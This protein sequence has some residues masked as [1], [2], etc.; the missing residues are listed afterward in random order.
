MMADL[1]IAFEGQETTG[2][3]V[4]ERIAKV[5]ER[6][7]RREITK[8]EEEKMPTLKEKH[9][10]PT[11]I[12]NTQ[13][14][15]IEP[16]MWR[17]LKA[18][19]RAGDFIQVKALKNY[20]YILTPLIKALELFKS[21]SDQDKA[22]E[23]VP[24]AYKLTGLMVKATNK[25]RM[26]V[27][28]K[29]HPD[30]KTICDPKKMTATLLLG[31]TTSEEIRK[32]KEGSR[33]TPFESPFFRQEGGP[34]TT[35]KILQGSIPLSGTLQHKQIPQLQQVQE[36]PKLGFQQKGIQFSEEEVNVGINN[37]LPFKL[38]NTTENFVAGKTNLFREN[39][40]NLTNDTWIM[41]TI[42]G[43][44]VEMAIQPVQISQPKPLKFSYEEQVLINLRD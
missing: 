24:D 5:T 35:E 38:L 30:Y 15:K 16:F 40:Y 3:V 1:E 10:R 27:K 9:R 19:I 17:H 32:I 8:K 26:E 43:Y 23:Y 2:P 44:E 21:K 11:N 39:W 36:E 4:Q 7:L 14:S 37:S 13:I 12:A 41:K 29:L 34:Q 6:A 31:Y 28:K 22:I 20:S 33:N 42:S 25:A 18:E